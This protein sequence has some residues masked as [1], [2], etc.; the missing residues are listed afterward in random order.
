M[1]CGDAEFKTA[2]P[3]NVVKLR[4]LLPY[5]RLHKQDLLSAQEVD[6]YASLVTHT[7]A[8]GGVSEKQHIRNVRSSRKNPL[9]PKCGSVM[10]QRTAKK[11]RHNGSKF[12]GCSN[13]P[14]CKA[15]KNMR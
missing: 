5:I 1:D 4:G 14:S 7:K 3:M 12:W 15:T 2:M 6:R 13:F 11:G 9:C 8:K 10:V